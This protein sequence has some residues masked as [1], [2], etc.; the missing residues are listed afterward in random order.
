MP[1]PK[2]FDKIVNFRLTEQAFQALE[3]LAGEKEK[4]VATL[5]REIVCERLA[6]K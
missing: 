2:T 4:H 6:T 1:K 3:D 5:V